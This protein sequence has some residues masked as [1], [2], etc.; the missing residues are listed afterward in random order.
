MSPIRQIRRQNPSLSLSRATRLALFVAISVAVLG[1]SGCSW[2]RKKDYYAAE[3]TQRPLEFPPSFDAAEA[4]RSLATTASG[5]V[6]R[7]SLPGTAQSGRTLGFSVSGDRAS[8]FG[9]VGEALTGISGVTVANRAQ[10]LGAYDI[11]YQG[12]KFLIRIT[13]AEGRST[14]SAVDPRGLPADNDAAAGL[15]AALRQALGGN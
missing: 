2:F 11:D 5:S 15:I 10:L 9:R 7:S 4:E 8:V 12:A 6:T 13:E 3:E 14:V 1:T